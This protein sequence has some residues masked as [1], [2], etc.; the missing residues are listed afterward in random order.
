LY[1][2]FKL[3]ADLHHIW[4]KKYREEML[5]TKSHSLTRSLWL[6]SI[7]TRSESAGAPCLYHGGKECYMVSLDWKEV[8][9]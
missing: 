5:G 7:L 9:T 3:K 6:S 4:L 8:Y 1:Q 2:L